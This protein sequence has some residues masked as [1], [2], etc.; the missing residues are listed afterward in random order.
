MVNNYVNAELE[1]SKKLCGRYF[2]AITVKII[3]ININI[4]KLCNIQK[5]LITY[6]Y[7]FVFRKRL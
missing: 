3:V 2:K 1:F 4:Q 5:E 6:C 7:R